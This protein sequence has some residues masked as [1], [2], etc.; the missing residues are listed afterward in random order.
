MEKS[1]SG[2][3]NEIIPDL[4]CFYQDP[5]WKNPDLGSGMKKSGSG[6]NIPD[7]LHLMLPTVLN[8]VESKQVRNATNK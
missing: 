3:Q 2:I 5:R 1:R 8:V 7:P 6:I 4:G